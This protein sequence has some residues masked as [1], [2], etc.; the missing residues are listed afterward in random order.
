MPIKPWDRCW[1]GV[2]F[3][4]DASEPILL[5]DGWFRQRPQR[6][7]GEP[8]R[9][10]LF[11]TRAKA[12]TWCKAT[13]DKYRHLGMGWKFTPVKVRELVEITGGR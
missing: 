13:T 10:L 2:E 7:I 6:N 8:P 5:I 4:T 12:R 11:D 3:C 1:W 9:V